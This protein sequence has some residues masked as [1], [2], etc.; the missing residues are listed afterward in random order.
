[1]L[2]LVDGGL[3]GR[4]EPAG[5]D[6]RRGELEHVGVTRALDQVAQLLA[7]VRHVGLDRASRA[8]GRLVAVHAV[9]Q[10]ID[11]DPT[12]DGLGEQGQDHPLLRPPDADR[13]AVQLG[14]QRT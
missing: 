9:D 5:V 1:V 6:R 3:V 13:G 2:K 11:A 14:L 4:L 10:V 8:G 12:A 7:Q